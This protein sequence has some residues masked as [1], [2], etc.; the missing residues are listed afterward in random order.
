MMDDEAEEE[1]EEEVAGLG[2]FGFTKAPSKKKEGEDERVVVRD[3]DFDNIVD[4]LSDGEGDEAAAE[5]ARLKMDM[6]EDKER[7]DEAR[8]TLGEPPS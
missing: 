5:A 4:E 3:D 2:D 1:E 8:R 7:R 6:K